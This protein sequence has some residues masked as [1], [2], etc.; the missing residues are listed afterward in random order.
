MSDN[1]IVLWNIS[2][3]TRMTFSTPHTAQVN[4]LKLLSDG[5]LASGSDDKYIK[6][7]DPLTG[8]LLQTLSDN[9]TNARI[10]TLEQLTSNGYLISGN[11]CYGKTCAGYCLC[12][13]STEPSIKV[14]NINTKSIVHTISN[15]HGKLSIYCLQELASLGLLAS[16]SYGGGSGSSDGPNLK[17]WNMTTYSLVRSLDGHTN[18][19]LVL[20][21][22]TNGYLLSGSADSTV[23]VW[24][25]VNGSMIK[26]L[27]P[28]NNDVMCLKQI[29]DGSIVV[30]GQDNS[31]YIY[32]TFIQASATVIAKNYLNSLGG[33]CNAFLLYANSVLATATNNGEIELMNISS[34]TGQSTYS[35]PNL[36]YSSKSTDV[37]CLESIGTFYLCIY[38][39]F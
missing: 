1:N 17:L 18:N 27:N 20:E 39:V 23:K 30:G 31:L 34:S 4:C 10:T 8:V 28:F 38:K 11:S 32:T 9:T 22:L 15:P 19:V 5:K 21:V 16:G 33:Q 3:N 25:P 29:A 12:S 36:S 6:I 13:T 2:T 26:S 35:T 24:N 14:W 37:L 7:W